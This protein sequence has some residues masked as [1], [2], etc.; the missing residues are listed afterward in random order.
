MWA[1][2]FRIFA[3]LSVS[4]VHV[5]CSRF[6][7]PRDDVHPTYQRY[8]L[9]VSTRGGKVRFEMSWKQRADKLALKSTNHSGNR[10]SQLSAGENGQWMLVFFEVFSVHLEFTR[11][12]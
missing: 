8:F 9:W 12:F 11:F 4:P 1:I 5:L 7:R 3:V 6:P 10:S 2:L